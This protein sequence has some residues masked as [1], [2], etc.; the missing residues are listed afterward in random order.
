MSENNDIKDYDKLRYSQRD[1]YGIV[2]KAATLFIMLALIYARFLAVET[3]QAEM[4]IQIDQLEAQVNKERGEMY[5]HVAEKEDAVM[6]RLDRKTSRIESQIQENK[7]Q[8]KRNTERVIVLE[9]T[10]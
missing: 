4:Q 2:A 7:D 5:R 9:T 1:V 8:T 10:D 6:G 3:N